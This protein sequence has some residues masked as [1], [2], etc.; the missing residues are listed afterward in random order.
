MKKRKVLLGVIKRSV[1]GLVH[2]C[3]RSRTS[4]GSYG[5]NSNGQI[6]T[7]SKLGKHLKNRLGLPEGKQLP[8][9]LCL[10]PQVIMG[11]ETFP[12]KTYLL[13]P[14]RGLQSKGDNEKSIF[15]YMLSRSR[16]VVENAFG[17][18]SQKFQIYQRTLQ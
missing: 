2:K 15:N 7:H 10:A 16:R 4:E 1:C 8:G 9:A 12:P 17:I 3:F 5:R 13:K 18:L 6:F 14:Y 11:D